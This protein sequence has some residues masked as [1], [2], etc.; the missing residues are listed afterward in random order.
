MLAYT[1]PKKISLY[2]TQIGV[3]VG[4]KI[5]IRFVN[6]EYKMPKLT[7]LDYFLILHCAKQGLDAA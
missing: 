1:C 2:I 6:V 3:Y 7:C 5:P 4:L